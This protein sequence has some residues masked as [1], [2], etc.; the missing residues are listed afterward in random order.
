MKSRSEFYAGE[1]DSRI[2]IIQKKNLNREDR[3]IENGFMDNED[4]SVEQ[5]NEEEVS[6]ERIV[7]QKPCR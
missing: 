1:I 6:R 2:L 5:S 3:G 7:S 4:E